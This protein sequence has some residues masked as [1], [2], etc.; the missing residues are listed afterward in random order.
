MAEDTVRDAVAHLRGHASGDLRFDEHLRSLKYVLAPD[1]RLVMPVMV[2]ML[3][4]MDTVLYV[5]EWSD[6]IDMLELQLTLEPFEESG[7]GG[8]LADRW[9]IH[10]GE[11]DDVRWASA[12]VDAARYRGMVIDGSA[13]MVPNTIAA[14][15]PALCRWMNTEH[16]AGL[17]RLCE[18]FGGMQVETPVMVGIDP[19][20]VNVRARFDVVRLR[21]PVEATSAQEARKSL[22]AMLQQVDND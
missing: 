6:D 18:R 4:T 15:E 19:M 20:G 22:E 10:H 7:L 13:L 21:F 16:S 12:L 5:P 17:G 2:A 1:G 9:R 11:P 8:A 14:E 3:Q